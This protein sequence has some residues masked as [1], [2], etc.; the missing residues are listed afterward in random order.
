MSKMSRYMNEIMEEYGGFYATPVQLSIIFGKDKDVVL[1][2][3]NAG[4]GIADAIENAPQSHDS[5]TPRQLKGI[6]INTLTLQE[7]EV[8]QNYLY[9]V[10]SFLEVHHMQYDDDMR[11][12]LYIALMSA[13]KRHYG[14]TNILHY[15][16]DSI[17][18]Q[19]LKVCHNRVIIALNQVSIE[20]QSVYQVEQQI[21]HSENTIDEAVE[22]WHLQSDREIAFQKLTEVERI[23][24]TARYGLEDGQEKTLTH[25]AEILSATTGRKYTNERIRQIQNKALRK[26]RHPNVRK[27]LAD[28]V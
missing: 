27:K 21:D 5:G 14:A 1:R 10:D 28:Y 3:Y 6:D 7:Q 8:V 13:V 25:T 19:Y 22:Y 2:M 12:E 16:S 17:A 9:M 11:Q 4:Y 20:E 23:V 18:Q 24:L 15:I 26:L